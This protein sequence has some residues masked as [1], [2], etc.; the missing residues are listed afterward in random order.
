MSSKDSEIKLE[1]VGWLHNCDGNLVALG[2]YWSFYVKQNAIEKV[3]FPG[4]ASAC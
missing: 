3:V 4:T 1:V 2:D